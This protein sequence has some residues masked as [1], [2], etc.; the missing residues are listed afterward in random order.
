VR[1]RLRLFSPRATALLTLLCLVGC[2]AA[3]TREE[4]L[5]TA[6][7][8]QLVPDMQ[9]L[10]RDAAELT[11]HLRALSADCPSL[12]AAQ[13]AWRRA[14]LSW[15]RV[16][17][18]RVGPLVDN[19]GLLRARFWPTRQ[20]ALEA[21]L[22]AP[23]PLSAA[24]VEQLG[25]DVRGMYALEWLLFV[26]PTQ[27]L[28][29]AT[30]AGTQKRAG[31]LAFAQNVQGYADR[32]LAQLGDGSALVSTL[33][34]EAQES[35]SRLVNQ[36]V[37]TVETL[38]SDRL[39]VVIEMAAHD[40]LRSSEVQAAASGLSQ[41]LVLVQ[42]AATEALYLGHQGDG[43][44]ALVRPVAGQIDE[45]VRARF[46]AARNLTEQLGAP[47]EVAVV[48]DRARVLAAFRALK[49]LELALKV[50]LA[51]ALGVTLTFTAGDGD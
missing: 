31:A 23:E 13:S 15:E 17:A 18:F 42:L 12:S 3:P 10:A 4:V 44:S 48:F 28:C 38:A 29:A 16:Y 37:A 40:D 11:V 47:L 2:T 32:A 35:V 51:S 20:A 25:V 19:S 9:A 6:V 41:Q 22:A 14:L 45:R 50:D 7:A 30:Q 33:R 5:R 36:M 46:V 43:L 27:G 39:A 24:A 26:E 1:G 21:R 34:V 49:E 8:R